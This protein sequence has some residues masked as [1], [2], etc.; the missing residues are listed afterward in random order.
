[1]FSIY[2]LLLTS[3]KR[4]N[5]HDDFNLHILNVSGKPLNLQV[6]NDVFNTEKLIQS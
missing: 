4:F 5:Y 1:M 6:N 2:Y 3:L